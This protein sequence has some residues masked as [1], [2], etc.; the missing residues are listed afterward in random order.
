MEWAQRWE[1]QCGACSGR[2]VGSCSVGRGVGAGVGVAVGLEDGAAVDAAVGAA[3]WGVEWACGDGHGSGDDGRR[4][5]GDR[6]Q[7]KST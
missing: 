7:S 4:L 5:G 3:V 1:L 6:L 2:S